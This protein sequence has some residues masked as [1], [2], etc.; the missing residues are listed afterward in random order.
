MDRL[1][2]SDTKGVLSELETSNGDIIS[3]DVTSN[4]SRSV[5][6]LELLVGVDE[7]GRALGPKEDVVT[8]L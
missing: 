3:D 7:A 6:D 4:S 5:S 1:S 2:E 8:L